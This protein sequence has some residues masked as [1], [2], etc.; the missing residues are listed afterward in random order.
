ML[1]S[2]SESPW[3]RQSAYPP[4]RK[5]LFLPRPSHRPASLHKYGRWLHHAKYF[6][7]FQNPAFRCGVLLCR[8]GCGNVHCR[9]QGC[10]YYLFQIQN[11]A[12]TSVHNSHHTRSVPPASQGSGP[13]RRF[14]A[15]CHLFL[16]LP[17]M[18][19]HSRSVPAQ[20]QS[21]S[22][23]QPKPDYGHF[24]LHLSNTEPHLLSGHP[25]YYSNSE[26][27]GTLTGS[28]QSNRPRQDDPAGHFGSGLAPFHTCKFQN[29]HGHRAPGSHE[30]PPEN[31]YGIAFPDPPLYT[32]PCTGKRTPF[33]RGKLL[34]QL[35]Q[36]IPPGA[37]FLWVYQP[38]NGGF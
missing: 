30:T 3:I 7:G 12:L 38:H 15:H 19:H 1:P 21:Y 33:P 25:G 6:H 27:A 22:G 8:S 34:H 9:N 26:T 23:T 16:H 2:Q 14:P 20:K 35:R 4:H 36:H 5:A 11:M 17:D 37:R 28:V 24:V 32:K 10:S 13:G 18:Q 31:G 29:H